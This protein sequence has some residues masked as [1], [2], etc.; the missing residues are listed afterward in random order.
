MQNRRIWPV[1][2]LP[3]IVAAAA[4]EKSETVTVAVFRA[5]LTQVN[6]PKSGGPASGTA[7]ILVTSN[8]VLTVRISAAGLDDV[9]HPQF[10]MSG[11]S[12]PTPANDINRDSIIDINEGASAWGTIITPISNTL[13]SPS[14]V[15]AG[16]P[17]GPSFTFVQTVAFGQFLGGLTPLGGAAIN[18]PTRT[19]IVTGVTPPVPPTVAAIPGLTAAQSVPVLCGPIVAR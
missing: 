17:T 13:G 6:A 5:A 10:L 14:V 3:L 16:F 11:S 19:I 15:L 2:A 7:T 18:F 8:Q 12:C 1:L 4:C 9:V